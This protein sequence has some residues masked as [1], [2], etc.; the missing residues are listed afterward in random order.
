SL[1]ENSRAHFMTKRFDRIEHDQ[2]LYIQTFC[3]MQHYDYNLVNSFSYQ[4]LFQTMRLLRLSY[5][6]AAQM[7]KRMVFNVMAKNRDDHTNNFAF[8]L[9]PKDQWKLAPAF[10]IC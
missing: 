10:A 5:P 1:E 7:F 8:T 4:Q 9:A 6:D 2:Q 3:A